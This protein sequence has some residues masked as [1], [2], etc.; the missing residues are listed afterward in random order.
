MYEMRCDV[1]IIG[2]GPA[3]YTAALYA[4]R[5]GLS[6]IVLEMLSPGGQMATTTEIDNY[7][8]FE[9]TV[10]GFDL[11]QKMK[12]GAERF[13]VES[14][15]A[16]VTEIDLQSDIKTIKTTSGDFEADTV[17]REFVRMHHGTITVKSEPGSQ[18][19]RRRGRKRTQR[20]RSIILRYMRRNDVQKQNRRCCRRRKLSGRGRSLSLQ[21]LRQSIY[22]TQKR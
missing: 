9:E 2:G 5:A 4:A 13:G 8:G 19:T 21:A 22:G 7:P 12:A 1:A 14:E 16:E 20:K 18:R 11:A 17:I 3:G 15:F 10:D 6:V